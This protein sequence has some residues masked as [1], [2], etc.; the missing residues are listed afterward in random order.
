MWAT[1]WLSCLGH[2]LIIEIRQRSVIT[3]RRYCVSKLPLVVP[4]LPPWPGPDMGSSGLWDLRGSLSIFSRCR[5]RLGWSL[6]S[7]SACG[8]WITGCASKSSIDF[9]LGARATHT[10]APLSLIVGSYSMCVPPSCLSPTVANICQIGDPCK[11]K[12][13]SWRRQQRND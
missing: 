3:L 4:T 5:L 2:E 9:F 1:I 13:G 10:R 7:G 8:L 12:I 6:N 11:M